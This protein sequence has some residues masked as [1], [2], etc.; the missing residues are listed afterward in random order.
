MHVSAYRRKNWGQE[1]QLP[2]GRGSSCPDGKLPRGVRLRRVQSGDSP[3]RWCTP[4]SHVHRAV[5]RGRHVL[6]PAPSCNSYSPRA[7]VYTRLEVIATAPHHTHPAALGWIRSSIPSDPVLTQLQS[8]PTQF[9]Q[10]DLNPVQ[11]SSNPVQSS[12]HP[13]QMQ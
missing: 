8:S 4:C 12:P 13:V 5:T 7:P 2:S 11:S 3:A 1:Q 9:K 10:S 6:P